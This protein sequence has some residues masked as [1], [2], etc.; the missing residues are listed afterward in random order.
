MSIITPVAAAI[1]YVMNERRKAKADKKK[2][3]LDE[4]EIERSYSERLSNR[5][6]SAEE[7]IERITKELTDERLKQN[8][9]IVPSDILRDFIDS[10]PGVSWVK[11]RISQSEFVMIRCSKGYAK[12][13]LEG[14]PELYDGKSD[15]EIWGQ[16]AA[17]SF[18]KTDEEVYKNAASA[19]GMRLPAYVAGLHGKVVQHETSKKDMT[20]TLSGNEYWEHPTT[21][22]IISKV[23]S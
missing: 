14:P 15:H 3:D 18:N 12:V 1:V 21:K 10:D 23:V 20:H 4:D 6:K 9:H 11:K 16:E 8:K 13:I 19:A 22:A 2:E 5:L 7:T 17:V